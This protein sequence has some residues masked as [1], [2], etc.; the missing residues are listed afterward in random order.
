MTLQSYVSQVLI[1]E[2]PLSSFEIL[3]VA[4]TASPHDPLYIWY[5]HIMRK[6]IT[7]YEG[8]RSN[9]SD[10]SMSSKSNN[11]S[12]RNRDNVSRNDIRTSGDQ[13]R[14]VKKK[15]RLFDHCTAEISKNGRVLLSITIYVST[16]IT[17][18]YSFVYSTETFVKVLCY[19]QMY[20]M[21]VLFVTY[22]FRLLVRF[23]MHICLCVRSK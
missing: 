8:E 23:C 16:H 15:S 2:D 1:L 22:R 3:L 18:L 11:S 12:N 5:K 9:Q 7:T 19:I 17:A 14:F 20:R 10:Q 4:L 13:T 6:E 21:L